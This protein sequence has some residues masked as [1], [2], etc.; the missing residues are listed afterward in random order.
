MTRL[1]VSWQKG[2]FM[3][4]TRSVDSSWPGEPEGVVGYR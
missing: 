3:Q 4:H 2:H 1:S